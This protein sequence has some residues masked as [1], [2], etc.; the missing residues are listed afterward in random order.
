MIKE[1]LTDY[2]PVYKDVADMIKNRSDEQ[3]SE[4]TLIETDQSDENQVPGSAS[5]RS[6]TVFNAEELTQLALKYGFSTL[7]TVILIIKNAF[8]GHV[9]LTYNIRPGQIFSQGTI[10]VQAEPELMIVSFYEHFARYKDGLGETWKILKEREK[11]LNSISF[12]ILAHSLIF[13]HL[14]RFPVSVFSGCDIRSFTEAMFMNQQEINQQ[15]ELCLLCERAIGEFELIRRVNLIYT[16]KF[17]EFVHQLSIKEEVFSHYQRRLEL[18]LYPNIHTEEELDDLMYKKLIEDKLNQTSQYLLKFSPDNYANYETPY[19]KSGITEGTKTLYRYISKNC[20]EVHS[21]QDCENKFTELNN[22]FL[23]ANSIYN[24]PV[25]N[26]SDALL[27][28]M[29]MILLL[30]QVVIF[31]KE[32]GFEI[33]GISQLIRNASDKD[34]LSRDELRLARRNLDSRLAAYRVKSLTDYKMKFV[35]DDELIEIHNHFLQKQLDFIDQQIIQIQS[36][37]KEV[38]LMKSQVKIL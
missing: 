16:E 31:R 4:Y 22:V 7:Q 21:I 15:S 11:D 17:N 25:L 32:K 12:E 9:L 3:I 23:E 26:L 20:S 38:L 13:S 1:I 35:I 18:A 33:A 8:E 14:I 5:S 37:I 28:Y 29:R 10:L 36:D 30:S 19:E 27:Q 34:S 6:Q 2:Y 24:E